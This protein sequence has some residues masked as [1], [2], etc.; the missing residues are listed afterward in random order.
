MTLNK[1][2]PFKVQLERVVPEPAKEKTSP[3]A[4][5]RAENLFK[6]Y[7]GKAVVNG[8]SLSIGTGEVVGLLGPNGAGKTTAFYMIM[9]LIRPD[10]GVVS[11]Q[12]RTITDLPVHA[13]ARLGMGYLAQEPSVFRQ[14]T[15]EDNILCIL[16]TLPISKKE[17]EARLTALLQELH[18]ERLA[19]KRASALSGGER[20]RLEITRAL[21]TQPALLLLDEPFANIDP[22]AVND[23]K[24]M[25]RHLKAKGISILITD[26]NAR[27]IFSIVDRSYL[28]REGKVLMSGSVDELLQSREARSTYF[29][30]NFRL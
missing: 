3:M 18:L 4:L 28:I 15:V 30:D 7:G 11:F 16:E 9:G 21:V 26:H 10:S 12:N 20:R 22:L 13:R 19:K 29:G 14:L 6:S 5:L 23:V 25:I 24:T 2:P 1:P 8:L 27:E 17:Q